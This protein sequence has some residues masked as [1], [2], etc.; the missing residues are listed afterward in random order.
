MQT[1]TWAQRLEGVLRCPPLSFCTYFQEQSPAEPGADVFS[2]DWQSA[3]PSDLPVCV[4]LGAGVI[5]MTPSHSS[6]PLSLLCCCC[7]SVEIRTQGLAY[8]RKAFLHRLFIVFLKRGL[9][10]ISTIIIITTTITIDDDDDDDNFSLF[11][12][13]FTVKSWLALNSLRRS[14]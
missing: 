3:S 7:C 2:L 12:M 10:I 6:S 1:Y 4:P 13:G 5:G 8:A 11:D 9:F 14:G